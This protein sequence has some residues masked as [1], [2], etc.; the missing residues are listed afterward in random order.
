MKLI[1][2]G[3]KQLNQE[4]IKSVPDL[5]PLETANMDGQDVGS[6]LLKIVTTIGS[7]V[8]NDVLMLNKISDLTS[9][10]KELEAQI[11]SE[12]LVSEQKAYEAR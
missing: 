1:E 5:R 7:V 10:R 6:R 12:R 2:T 4:Y 3:I 8:S 11:G 9:K